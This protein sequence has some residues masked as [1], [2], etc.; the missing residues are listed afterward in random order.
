MAVHRFSNASVCA[1]LEV[2]ERDFT[3]IR[4]AMEARGFAYSGKNPG[5]PER[6]RLSAE[7]V[8]A[9]FYPPAEGVVRG[10][11]LNGPSEPVGVV[12]GDIRIRGGVGIQL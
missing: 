10:P 5:P 11:S 8:H 6:R 2:S 3:Q 4:N 9:I 7:E 1:D 12:A